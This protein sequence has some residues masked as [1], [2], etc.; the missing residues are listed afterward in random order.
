LAGQTLLR[1]AHAVRS[2]GQLSHRGSFG[3]TL[4]PELKEQRLESVKRRS[5]GGSASGHLARHAVC[6]TVVGA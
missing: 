2:T 1:L 6:E 4:L 3:R 5:V